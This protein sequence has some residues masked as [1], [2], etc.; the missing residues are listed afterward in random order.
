MSFPE[1][2]DYVEDNIEIGFNR[3][4]L[5]MGQKHTLLN[6]DIVWGAQYSHH[7]VLCIL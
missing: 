4:T 1:M 2:F 6:I 7:F 3:M 5:K